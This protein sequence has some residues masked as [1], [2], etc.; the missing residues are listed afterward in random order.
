MWGA[1]KKQSQT[2]L[3]TLDYMER[4][5]RVG[6]V[7]GTGKGQRDQPFCQRPSRPLAANAVDTSRSRAK[8]LFRVLDLRR[9]R[10]VVEEV[11][12]PEL[13]PESEGRTVGGGGGRESHA[14]RKWGGSSRRAS[15]QEA[16]PRITGG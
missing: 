14:P 12:R 2:G 4:A 8:E 16:A 9:R 13:Q 7:K 1:G 6:K 10:R 11:P 3:S 5:R 15:Q